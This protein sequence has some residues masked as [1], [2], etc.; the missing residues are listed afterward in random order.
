MIN[1]VLC[2]GSGTRL[3]PLSRKLMPKQF[4]NINGQSSLFQQTVERNNSFADSFCLVSARDYQFLAEHQIAGSVKKESAISYILE[5]VGRNTAPAI[6][7][8]CFHY[9]AEDLVLVTPSDHV[10]LDTDEY[11]T[12]IKIAQ[13][14][15]EKGRL[16]TFG[17]K[18]GYPE[19][20]YGYIETVDSGAAVKVKSFKEKPEYATAQEYCS[21]GK[22]FWNSGMFMFKAGVFLSELK[23]YSPGIYDS[24]SKAYSLSIKELSGKSTTIAVHEKD[25]LSIPAD[26]IDYAV[27]EKSDNVYVVP[28]EIGWNDLGSFD[29]LYDAGQKDSSGNCF[30]GNVAS[31]ESKGNFV[32]GSARK[33]VLAGVE[34]L[35]V[36]DTPD[37]LLLCQ[38]N[39]SQ[40]VKDVVA[41][42]QKSGGK[43][44]ELTVLPATVHRPWGTYTV[45][46]EGKN[47]KIKNITVNPGKRLSLQK[48]IHRS[49]HWVVVC[50][51]ATIT[52]GADEKIVKPNES[53]YIPIGE[54]HRLANNGK[55]DL[56]IIETQVGE[57]L[58][59]DDIIRIED[60]FKR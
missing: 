52:V 27:M 28:S 49:E 39:K 20:G 9:N 38:R 11:A 15:A 21:S 19:T 43:D 54:I 34:N 37:A 47:Y 6:A 23:K 59:E 60:D 58:G 4:T 22:Y 14:E 5:P 31:I 25:M 57:Y 51:T 33:A 32:L 56:T 48:H 44:A 13:T 53:T 46:E 8:A 16:V 42:L 41:M 2:G 40:M 29:S 18:P 50:G 35:I 10:I 26:S 30:S 55:I 3:W 17:I 1:L 7:L 12:V 24:A 45:L 36:I